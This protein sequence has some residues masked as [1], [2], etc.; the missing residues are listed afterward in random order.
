MKIAIT[1]GSGFIGTRL[2]EELKKDGAEYSLPSFYPDRFG[3]ELDLPT[4]EDRL[5]FQASRI[6]D[7]SVTMCA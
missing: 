2:I 7:Y 5:Q 1:G 3:S 6:G 4:A